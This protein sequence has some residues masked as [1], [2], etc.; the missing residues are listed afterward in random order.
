MFF[1]NNI[2][3]FT[4]TDFL[5]N[6][7][8]AEF[9]RTN[10]KHYEIIKPKLI[11]RKKELANYL[12]KYFY[13]ID[14]F[15]IHTKYDEVSIHTRN[16]KNYD[17]NMKKIF[18]FLPEIF[19]FIQN[20]N[21]DHLNLGCLTSYGGYPKCINQIIPTITPKE[22]N[23]IV[24]QLLILLQKNTTIKV[25]NIGVFQHYIDMDILKNMMNNN[26]SLDYVSI[27]AN[28]ST[29]NF[30]KPPT[31]LYRKTNGEFIWSHFRP[32]ITTN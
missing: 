25:C 26:Q 16:D 31:T 12:I 29:T 23:M 6:F 22:I 19:D 17:N 21:I 3:Y 14:N 27:K 20:N 24:N 4:I 11:K 2:L 10:N 15:S 30:N 9:S 28:G 7:D 5:D 18:W 1:T 8:L 13:Y 32:T